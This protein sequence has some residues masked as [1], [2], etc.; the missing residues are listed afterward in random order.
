M[1]YYNAMLSEMEAVRHQMRRPKKNKENENALQEVQQ[2]TDK[3][4]FSD[5]GFKQYALTFSPLSFDAVSIFLKQI[6]TT[7]HDLIV[8]PDLYKEQV[9]RDHKGYIISTLD[10]IS[11]ESLVN[12]N[13]LVWASER[14]DKGAKIARYFYR[15]SKAV[16][17]MKNIGPARVWMHDDRKEK[18]LLSEYERQTCEGI[19]KFSHGIGADFGNLLQFI[20]NAKGLDGDFVEIGCFM[21]SSTCVMAN[22][23]EQNEIEKKFFVYDYFDGFNYEE[24]EQSF[25]AFWAGTHVTDGKEKVEKRVKSRLKKLSDNFYFFQRNIID[26]DALKEVKKISF[27]NIDVDMYEAVY[28]AL[29]HVH[30]KLCLNGIVA[31]ED[32]GHTPLLLGAKIA[33]EEFLN[34]VGRDAYHVLQMESGQYV[35]IRR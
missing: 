29:V 31:V 9:R 11:K 10:Y 20:D 24:A 12:F 16:V 34:L 22:Y 32:A 26:N 21:G 27:A 6:E 33:L 2:L 28:A 35:L 4:G 14:V 1:N 13:R 3:V 15:T 19:E 23:M 8:I 5:P 7:D 25:D 18:V 30:D 17:V